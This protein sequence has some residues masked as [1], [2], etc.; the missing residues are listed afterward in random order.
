MK[1]KIDTGELRLFITDNY[2]SDAA[3]ARDYGIDRGYLSR[4]L[5]GQQAG[6]QLIIRLLLRGIRSVLT[7]VDDP[8]VSGG[9]K[10]RAG[11]ARPM[12]DKNKEV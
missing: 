1:V 12:A 8:P 7:C 11:L 5:S 10:A 4:I 2:E 6:K 3:F 9:R